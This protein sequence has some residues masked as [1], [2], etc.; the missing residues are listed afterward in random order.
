MK[1]HEDNKS[2]KC[3]KWKKRGEEKQNKKRFQDN[4]IKNKAAFFGSSCDCSSS[5]FISSLDFK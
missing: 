3:P 2:K 1:N 5:N 4:R